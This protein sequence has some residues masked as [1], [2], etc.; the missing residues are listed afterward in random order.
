MRRPPCTH[1]VIFPSLLALKCHNQRS[2]YPKDWHTIPR[3]RQPRGW[4]NE[5]KKF[6]KAL[7]PFRSTETLR[8][9]ILTAR[10]GNTRATSS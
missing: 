2:D 7:E 8:P 6:C 9:G 5:K 1:L 10:P 3:Y 4:D